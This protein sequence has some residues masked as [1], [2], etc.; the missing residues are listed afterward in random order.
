MSIRLLL[1]ATAL[2]LTAPARAADDIDRIN[3]LLQD[4]FRRLSE[5]LGAALS[6][7]A[8]APPEPLG[9]TGFDIGLEVSAT[10]LEQRDAWDR[11]ISGSAPS[12]IYL[13]KVHLHKGLPAGFDIA[14]FYAGAPGT[15]VELWGGE[16]RYALIAGSAALPAVGL[17][18]TYTQ[19]DGV[20]QLNF[21]T[22]GLELGIS[23][24]FAIATPYAGIG[25]IRSNSEPRVNNL[26]SEKFTQSK[27]FAGVNLNFGLLNLAFEGDK[28]GDATTYSGKLGWRF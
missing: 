8:L 17:R 26:Q 20:D 4:E 2:L 15:N 27:V 5:D 1:L 10:R 14:A 24:G 7:K 19:L 21:D 25:R 16:L 11:A 12:T 28:T 9:V 22:R 6:Y 23:K 3:L 18:A 13:P